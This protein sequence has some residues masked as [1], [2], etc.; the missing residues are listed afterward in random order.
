METINQAII[1]L[2]TSAIAPIFL[3]MAVLLIG[4]LVYAKGGEYSLKLQYFYHTTYFTFYNFVFAYC[5]LAILIVFINRHLLQWDNL[6][7]LYQYASANPMTGLNDMFMNLQHIEYWIFASALIAITT[8]V[9]FFKTWRAP[10]AELKRNERKTMRKL[11]WHLPKKPNVDID[12]NGVI[13]GTPGSGKTA[14]VLRIILAKIIQNLPVVVV[15]GKGDIGQFSIYDV[16]SKLARKF[17]RPLYVINQTISDDSDPYNPFI[18]RNATQ[19]K[20]MLISM[21][22]WSDNASHYKGQ[23]SRYW[24]AMASYM[25]EFG[26]PIS[27][28]TLIHY[29]NS[30]EWAQAIINNIELEDMEDTSLPTSVRKQLLDRFGEFALSKSR[31]KYLRIILECGDDVEKNTS[32]FSTIYEG[33]GH[34]LF[35]GKNTFNL[36]T[37]IDTNAV[38][39]V[40]LNKMAYGDFATGLGHLV[41]QDFKNSLADKMMRKLNQKVLAVFDEIGAYFDDELVD[42][43]A[44]IRSL[45]GYALYSM[46]GVSDIDV[47]DKNVRRQIMNNAN[48]ACVFKQNDSDDAI[49]AADYLGTDEVVN[50]TAQVEDMGTSHAGTGTG[51]NKITREY[52][53]NPEVIKM[54]PKLRGIWF[55]KSNKHQRPFVFKVEYVDVEGVELPN[56]NDREYRRKTGEWNGSP[57]LP[58]HRLEG[59]NNG[60]PTP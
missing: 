33:E 43:S 9:I 17:G 29:S 31:V 39:I 32:S 37:I 1:T 2:I 53:F 27:F 55:D 6:V 60:S 46:Q 52:R 25:L 14:M 56:K 30:S 21:G 3:I 26:I 51:T 19:I 12:V 45:N 54:L 48:F 13:V 57:G 5:L 58:L 49:A 24:Q 41:I 11:F 7:N 38:L 34:K 4:Y 23:A 22:D 35:D 40:L 10:K 18:N 15:D 47:I 59:E 8:T 28:K 44:R 20:D 42:V 36:S 16:V 50:T